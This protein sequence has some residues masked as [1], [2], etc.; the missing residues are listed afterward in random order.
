MKPVRG[1]TYLKMRRERDSYK[2]LYEQAELALE[3]IRSLV[4]DVV[5]SPPENYIRRS[6]DE[7]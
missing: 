3:A 7:I 2:H 1:E 4:I 6:Y 5:G